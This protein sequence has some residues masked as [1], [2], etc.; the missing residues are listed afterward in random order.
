VLSEQRSGTLITWS[1]TFDPRIPFTGPL[2]A[3]AYRRL[4]GSF[5]RRLAAYAEQA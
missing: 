4:I 1:A 3:R 2:L 5:A